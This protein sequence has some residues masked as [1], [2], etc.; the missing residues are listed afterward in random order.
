[1]N[2]IELQL[3][4]RQ[5]ALKAFFQQHSFEHL[6]ADAWW[7]DNYIYTAEIET[8]E[9]DFILGIDTD[10][11]PD[12]WIN[13]EAGVTIEGGHFTPIYKEHY[14]DDRD[15]ALRENHTPTDI[16]RSFTDLIEILEA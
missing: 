16:F 6:I 4:N 2:M 14:Y 9:G 3:T 15:E 8:P 11:L 5:P 10:L 13:M 12:E 7:D 1:M